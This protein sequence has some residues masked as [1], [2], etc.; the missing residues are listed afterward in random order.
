[1]LPVQG[2]P[3][4]VVRALVREHQIMTTPR[5]GGVRISTHGYNSMEDVDRVVRALDALGVKPATAAG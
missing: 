2:D 1:M 5:G 4:E 3:A